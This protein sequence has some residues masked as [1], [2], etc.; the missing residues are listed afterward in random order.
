MEMFLAI[1]DYDDD[2]VM[3]TLVLFIV[4]YCC[5]LLICLFGFLCLLCYAIMILI[6]SLLIYNIR[7]VIPI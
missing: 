2:D 5:L 7:T 6:V 3:M 4:I 1:D